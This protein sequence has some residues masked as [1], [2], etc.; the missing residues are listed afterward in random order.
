M[1]DFY[2]PYTS[3]GSERWAWLRLPPRLSEA[4]GSYAD[5]AADAL[6][7]RGEECHFA[8]FDGPVAAG[9]SLRQ[10]S[11]RGYLFSGAF[12][13]SLASF[14]DAMSATDGLPLGALTSLPGGCVCIAGSGLSAIGKGVAECLCYLDSDNSGRPVLRVIFFLMTGAV[15]PAWVYLDRDGAFLNCLPS[16]EDLV[17][18]ALTP[19]AHGHRRALALLCGDVFSDGPFPYGVYNALLR[20]VQ[21]CLY[22]VSKEPDIQ[23]VPSE[24]QAGLALYS[25]G[26]S[27][28]ADA[29]EPIQNGHGVA[30]GG[31]RAAHVRRAHW[32]NYW[33]KSS[34]GSRILV[35]KWVAETQVKSSAEKSK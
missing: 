10:A 18:S 35:P 26:A 29:E 22:L 7:Q 8:A 25:V 32:H 5:R 16:V 17:G 28:Y 24:K 27:Y 9:F 33:V 21:H 15:V 23:S 1:S 3:A 6:M 20:V 34:D 12:S 13:D 2:F 30:S 11:A 4:D 19:A 14:C 31:S